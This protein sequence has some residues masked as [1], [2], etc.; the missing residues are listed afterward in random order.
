M[1]IIGPSGS[2]F[3]PA[4]PGPIGGT[5][6]STGAFTT[7]TA[8]TL[9]VTKTGH[10]YSLDNDNDPFVLSLKFDGV[11]KATINN[12]GSFDGNAFNAGTAFFV[13]G[14]KVVGVQQAAVADASG[15]AII[16]AECRAALNS[17]L[18]KLRT[19]GLIA[20]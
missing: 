3:N 2:S 12:A 17:L 7:V 9:A 18:A 14:T 15:G 1:I 11:Q 19:H 10:T 13:A 16:D 8:G 20:P 4:A 6:P 5:T